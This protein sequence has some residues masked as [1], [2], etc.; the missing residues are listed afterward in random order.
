MERKAIRETDRDHSERYSMSSCTQK[1]TPDIQFPGNSMG[2]ETIATGT[3]SRVTA[4]STQETSDKQHSTSGL[5]PIATVSPR[6]KIR[7]NLE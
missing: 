1:R 6:I 4:S 2:F 5:P 3:N 7:Y